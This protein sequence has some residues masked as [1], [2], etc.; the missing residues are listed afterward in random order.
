MAGLVRL[1]LSARALPRSLPAVRTFFAYDKQTPVQPSLVEQ[2]LRDE[3]L[4]Q[5]DEIILIPS[6]SI[7]YPECEKIVSSPFGNIYAEGQPDLRLSRVSPALATD[8][9]YFHAWHRRLSDGRF[10]RGC[11]ES[12]RVELLA[13]HYIASAFERLE[14][15][16]KAENIFANVQALS[17]SPANL[18]IYTALLMPNDNILTLHLSHG[19]HLSHGSPFNVS[20]KYYNATQYEIDPTTRQLDYDE[21]HRLA[22]ESRPRM[23]VGGASAYPMDWDWARLREIADDVG[24]LLHADVCHLAGLIVGGQLKNPLPYSD[25]VMFTTHKTLMGPRGAVIVSKCK[26]I[27]RKIDNAVFPGMQGGPHMNSIAGIARMFELI[28]HH[29]DD[30]Q[31]L[32][33]RIVENSKAFGAQLEQRGFRLEYGGTENHMVLLDLK[34]FNVAQGTALDGETASRLLENV[35]IVVNKNTLPGDETAAD[36]SG[37]RVATPWITQRGITS[38]QITEL[39][40]IIHELLASAQG[41][42]VW[43]PS[44]EE[45]CRARVPYEQLQKSRARVKALARSL[46]YPK[47][48]DADYN[49]ALFDPLRDTA[50]VADRVAMTVRGEKAQLGLDQAITADVG[51]LEPGQATT[52]QLRL[53]DG[54]VLAE[55]QVGYV[56]WRNSIAAGHNGEHVYVLLAQEDKA[57]EV[58]DWLTAMSD[59]Y[60]SLS[61]KDPYAKVDGPLAIH[62]IAQDTL[63]DQLANNLVAAVAQQPVV[64][65]DKPY[66]VGQDPVVDRPLPT[67]EWEAPHGPEKRTVLH[68]WHVENGGQMVNFGGWEMPVKYGTSIND[69]HRAVRTSAALFDVSHMSAVAVEGPHALPFLETVMANTAA[70]LVDNEAQYSYLL[71]ENGVA[72]DDAYVYR[73]NQE[74]YMVVFNAGNFEQDMA[75]LNAVNQGQVCIDPSNPGKRLAHSANIYPL[76]DAGDKSLLDIA[77]Q[78]PES[79]EI[80]ARTVSQ[81]QAR[82]LHNGKLNDIHHLNIGDVP[83]IAARTGY[84]GENVGFELFVHPDDTLTVWRTLLDAGKEDGVIAAGLGARDSAR[85]EAGFP[86]FGHELEGDEALSLTEADYGYVSRF[87]RPFYIG[88]DA[89]IQRTH[90]RQKRIIRLTGNGRKSAR[91]GHAVLDKDGNVVGTVT[92]FAF[93]DSEFNYTVLAAVDASFTPPPAG[94]VTIARMK[95]DKVAAGVKGKTIDLYVKTRFPNVVE[96]HDW[97][98]RYAVMQ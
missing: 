31:D 15:D 73:F 3:T 58:Y 18:A 42:Q 14:G 83:V 86:L 46:P 19:G 49:D 95:P 70:R 71:R 32:Q 48:D 9:D 76:R 27:A 59:G 93:T 51:G 30:Y 64:V 47:L 56:G 63:D 12:D 80:L 67:F 22:Q 60:V 40:D 28:N 41:F 23:I 37:L 90:P 44:G 25:T 54:S 21:I 92:S 34:P 4:R 1:Q 50:R 45:K 96:K 43:A 85:I 8:R 84:T 79:L 57:R 72:L 6:E 65:A 39:A 5:R 29:Y 69:E 11:N 98:I 53:A 2:S 10:Y 82:E 78:G 35:G 13:K 36:S 26:D 20:G 61:P 77:F 68:G 33:R 94:T 89:Y 17:G 91:P 24:A 81:E 38:E 87:H 75:W 7:C 66:F 74:R 52:G 97:R 62:A 88:R 55:V 16:L